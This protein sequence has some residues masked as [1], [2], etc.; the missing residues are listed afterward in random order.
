MYSWY[1]KA[2]VCYAY[3]SDVRKSRDPDQTAFSF[4]R[5]N[6]FQ[7]GWTL[8][9][10]LAPSNLVFLDKAWEYLGTRKSRK[11]DIA[12]CTTI[13]VRHIDSFAS[14]YVHQVSV[15]ERLSWIEG[16][17]PTRREDQSYFLL[18]LFEIN[19]PLL[20][21][22]GSSAFK[23]LQEEVIRSSNDES[24]FLWRKFS[25][26]YGGER[27]TGRILADS[28]RKFDTVV[29]RNDSREEGSKIPGL[30]RPPFS[31][32][33]QGLEFRVPARLL[34]GAQS[35]I[36]PFNSRC[37]VGGVLK[38]AYA[39]QLEKDSSEGLWVRKPSDGSL[40]HRDVSEPFRYKKSTSEH[41]QYLPGL[42]ERV[43]DLKH[44]LDLYVVPIGWVWSRETLVQ[45]ESE[46]IYLK[47]SRGVY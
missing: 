34:R 37:F 24:I 3:L 7:R 4:Q 41:L 17:I 13:A 36:L 28:P 44:T 40:I 35:I 16:R 30:N 38:G 20:Y 33:N 10:L 29:G 11:V 22:E 31:I 1:G 2:H 5:S 25:Y 14:S 27:Y 23:R 32:S 21:G 18:G 45:D 15:A 9:E 6:W 42:V 19:M 46:I 26:R 8:Q 12:F 39:I 43:G 47:T